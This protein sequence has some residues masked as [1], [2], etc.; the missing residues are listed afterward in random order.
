MSENLSE[1]KSISQSELRQA[2]F[3]HPVH[4]LALGFGTGL[5]PKAPGTAGTLAALPFILLTAS[6]PLMVKL[7]ALLLLCIS[8]IWLCGKSAELLGVHDHGAI[9]WDEIAGYYL[10]AL[11]IPVSALGL[12]LGFIV[13]RIFDI[14]KPWPIRQLD[15][16]VH[17]GLGIMLDDLV[18]GLLAGGV[19][20]LLQFVLMQ[21]T[22]FV[23]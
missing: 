17:G 4:W 19:I 6:Q 5:V 21:T 22:G 7:L 14:L 2:F 23:L 3:K 1:K 20:C 12:L 15:A 9:V 8:G 11:F 10:T 13:F 16:Q 18:A